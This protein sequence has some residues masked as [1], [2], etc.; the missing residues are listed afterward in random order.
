MAERILKG[1][2]QP[3]DIPVETQ[4]EVSLVINLKAAREMGVI[5]PRSVLDRAQETIE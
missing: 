5:L 1:E 3:A 2:A 4:K